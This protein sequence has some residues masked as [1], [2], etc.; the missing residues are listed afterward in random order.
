VER[1]IHE[2]S[3]RAGQ[4]IGD[5]SEQELAKR[6]RAYRGASKKQPEIRLVARDEKRPRGVVGTSVVL[7]APV[8]VFAIGPPRPTLRHND[9][10][11]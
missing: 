2:N 11:Y 4:F 8:A 7:G 10:G 5:V 1:R 9:G 3:A 6:V